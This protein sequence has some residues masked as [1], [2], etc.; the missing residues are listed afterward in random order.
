M[1]VMCDVENHQASIRE[2]SKVCVVMGYTMIVAWSYVPVPS[3]VS[4][5][6]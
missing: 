1:M 3:R 2:L 5:R 6:S 4:T